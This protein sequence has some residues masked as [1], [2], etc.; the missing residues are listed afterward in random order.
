MKDYTDIINVEYRG[1]K[2]ARRLNC[3]A[4]AAIFAPFAALER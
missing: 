2:K 4:R 1:I 3:G